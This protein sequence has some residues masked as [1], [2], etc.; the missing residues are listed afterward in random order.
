MQRRTK[1]ATPKQTTSAQAN[2]TPE[3]HTAQA[4]ESVADPSASTALFAYPHSTT[5]R[6]AATTAIS[7]THG[8]QHLQRLLANQVQRHTSVE[9]EEPENAIQRHT[10]VE[11]EEPEN[12]IQRFLIQRDLA[13]EL[14]EAME[15]WGT[16]E[17]AIFDA[18]DRA[19]VDSRRAILNN[20]PILAE[21]SDELDQ[22]D[23]LTALFKLGAPIADQLDAAMAGA[24]TDEAAIFRVIE[25]PNTTAADKQAVLRNSALM[26]RLRDELS[27]A[28]VGRAMRGLGASL[29]E[30]IYAAIEGIGTEEQAIMDA[31]A[32]APADQ[33]QAA[34]HDRALMQR[35]WDDL[36][37]SEMD[38][39]LVA[40]GASLADRLNSFMDGLGTDE[41]G[42][43][44]VAAS[45]NDA[46]RREILSNSLLMARLRDELTRSEMLRLLESL[47]ASLP[48]RLNVAMDSWG[49]DA[50]EI[51]A[52]VT[53]ASEA[54]RTMLRENTALVARL[55]SELTA[56]MFTQIGNLIGLP[57]PTTTD[58]AG[59]T[60]ADA[61]G[62][63]VDADADDI[64]VDA[65]TGASP[66]VGPTTL[67]GKVSEALDK[68]PPDG[69]AALAAITAA[70]AD[71]RAT[72][73]SD[74]ALRD[75]FYAALDLAQL[76]QAFT[77]LQIPIVARVAALMDRNVAF[78]DLQAHLTA[79]TPDEKR[80]ILDDRTLIERMLT[81]VGTAQQDALM[82]TLGDSLNNR[83]D[84]LL[85]N[86]PTTAALWNLIRPADQASRDQVMANSMLMGR[87]AA[88]ISSYE[89]FQTQL[90]LIYGN[91][92]AY[93]P[94]LQT[95]IAALSGTPTLASIRTPLGNI[96][97][98]DLT[99]IK[100]A[101]RE[102]MRLLLNDV[103]FETLGRFL[104]QGLIFEE[105]INQNWNETLQTGAPTG[106]F[107][108]QVFTGN[109]GFDVGYYRDRVQVTVRIQF[110]AMSGDTQA[111][112]DLP[113]LMTGWETLLE[114]SWSNRFRLQ[115]AVRNLPIMIDMVYN[116]GTPHH[117]VNVGSA[118][119]VA[120]P[121]YNTANWFYRATAYNHTNAPLHEFGHMLGNPDEYMLSA[122]DYQNTVGTAP[123]SDPNAVATSDSAGNQRFANSTSLMGSGGTVERRHLNYFTNWL[124]GHRQAGEPAYT[125]V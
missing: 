74:T 59:G 86:T 88:A 110:E 97:D 63:D 37:W 27:Q 84:Q 20:Q 19:T 99:K 95:L 41:D 30:Q 85:A 60:T 43:Y 18:I 36:T 7:R 105:T 6:S 96:A 61:G 76:Q 121:G 100:G 21:L 119:T 33:K 122:I 68:T 57:Q 62:T 34:L 35:L 111:E 78:A 14:T 65:I 93:D 1:R 112:T 45:A 3:P 77:T 11:L 15:G 125:L 67:V 120:W 39:A 98:A 64:E 13:S 2:H 71:E 32:A 83:I 124:N 115:N 44:A 56:E 22:S 109:Q 52:L 46:Q 42:I 102:Y 49:A 50:P 17:Q 29:T 38:Q 4:A 101:L 47:K 28:D 90:L 106:T 23:L 92:T 70:T 103:D 91:E 79:A 24:G 123:G 40:L 118:T 16:D 5:Q 107:T 48:D 55:R 114:G 116:S 113:A 117:H 69:A 72:V 54:E 26:A 82:Q 25:S 58:G 31:I 73:T 75:R 12:A 80:A 81:F 66:V 104:D 9:L 108:P 94:A 53:A 51:L 10:S 89:F 8:N 87:M